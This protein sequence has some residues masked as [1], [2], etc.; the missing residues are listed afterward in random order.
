MSDYKLAVNLRPVVSRLT[1]TNTGASEC[2][3]EIRAGRVMNFRIIRKTNKQH[4]Q[5]QN[6]TKKK[7]TVNFGSL[8]TVVCFSL[9]SLCNGITIFEVYLMLKPPL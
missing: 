3:L 6:K 2:N 1:D 5:N 8:K 7:K 4:P 9:V